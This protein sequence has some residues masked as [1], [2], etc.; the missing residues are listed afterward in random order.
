M[1]TPHVFGDFD[2]LV[3]IV[4]HP[5][6]ARDVGV[7]MLTAGMLHNTGPFRMYVHLARSLAQQGIPSLRF[8]LSG[9]GE[10]LPVASSGTSLQR[11]ANETRQAMDLLQDT[12]GIE[13]FV[14]FGLCSGADDGF[15]TALNESRVAGFVAL[16]GCGYPTP[17][18][19]K[20]RLKSHYIPRLFS[21]TFWM[22]K[23]RPDPVA[24]GS[25]RI[26]DDI[27]EFPSRD[28]AAVELQSLVDRDVML[29]FIYTGGVA[30]YFNHEA[31]FEK[32]FHDVDFRG[33][34][35]CKYFPEMDHVAI[36]CEDREMLL[37]DITSWVDRTFANSN[38][39]STSQTSPEKS[40]RETAEQSTDKSTTPSSVFCPSAPASIE[41]AIPHSVPVDTG[42]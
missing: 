42:N 7:I 20:H 27:R 23:L 24:S 30:H 5:Q 31:Q 36:L 37:T 26:G 33:N 39:D 25:L 14:L 10:S 18:F 1:E 2:H 15:H 11:A 16:D 3:G 22:Q 40:T 28:Q 13:R 4:N 8:D 38:D 29:R 6:A 32:M 9:I 34:V 41:P 12:Y 35:T 21:P 19:F 17:G